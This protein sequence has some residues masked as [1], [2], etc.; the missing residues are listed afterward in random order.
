MEEDLKL[1][2]LKKLEEICKKYGYQIVKKPI[3][4]CL[5]AEPDLATGYQSEKDLVCRNCCDTCDIC[6]DLVTQTYSE[7]EESGC[8]DCMT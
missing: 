3:C 7:G 8:Y 6:G 4:G 1:N 5:Y 2:N